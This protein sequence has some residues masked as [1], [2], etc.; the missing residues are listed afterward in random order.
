MLL[1]LP[2]DV[3]Q[4]DISRYRERIVATDNKLAQLP[5]TSPDWRERKKIIAKRR[6]FKEEIIHVGKLITM[7]EEALKLT[8]AA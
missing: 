8:Q 6:F 4:Q 1:E 7:A 3:I 5:K 2:A